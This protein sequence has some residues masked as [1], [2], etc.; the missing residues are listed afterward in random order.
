MPEPEF[1][2]TYYESCLL[3][4]LRGILIRRVP[5]FLIDC[6]PFDRI[7]WTWMP[8]DNRTQDEWEI[9]MGRIQVNP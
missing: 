4:A 5:Y 8:E 1:T 2:Q 3:E 9:H 7:G 6:P